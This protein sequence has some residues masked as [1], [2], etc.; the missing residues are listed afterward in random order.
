ML[1]NKYF[2]LYCDPD[3]TGAHQETCPKFSE[4]KRSKRKYQKSIE[5]VFRELFRVEI[6]NDK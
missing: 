1:T 5:E 4:R 3:E 2:C 6:T